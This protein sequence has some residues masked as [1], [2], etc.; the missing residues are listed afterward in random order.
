MFIE[1][2]QITMNY[3]SRMKVF[4]CLEQLIHDVLFVDVFQYTAS[5]DDI[6]QI[7]VWT[8]IVDKTQTSLQIENIQDK[9]INDIH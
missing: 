3:I 1:Y 5:L 2:L 7:C 4:G 6:V 8:T 9:I